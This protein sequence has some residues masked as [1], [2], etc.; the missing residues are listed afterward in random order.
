M[1]ISKVTS[2]GI[3][4]GTLSVEDIKDDAVTAAKLANSINTDI[5][6][7]VTGNTTANAALPK[8]GGAMTGAITTNSTFDGVDI[9]TRDGVLT[10]TTATAAAALPKAGGAMTGT[11][12][13]LR[14]TGIDDNA[15][16][17]AMTIDSSENVGVGVTSI[18]TWTKLKVAGT[19]GAQDVAK[20]ALYVTSPT[21]TANEG[22]GMRFSA[23]SGSHEA[24]GIIGM[25][26]NP[27]GNSGAM[28]F[29]TYNG[30]GTIPERMRIDNAGKVGIGTTA[31]ARTLHVNSAD[32]NI[33]SFEGHQGEGLV[34]SSGTNG[35]IDI[36]GYDD[37]ASAYNPI[38]IRAGSSG[39]R[40]TSNGLCFGAD[41]AAANALDDYEEGAWSPSIEAAN[42]NAANFTVGSAMYTKIGRQVNVTA[43]IH[44]IDLTAMTSG[45]Y[46][47][48][49]GLPYTSQDYADFAMGYR[50]AGYSNS[51]I[52]GGYVQSG[53]T[54]C[55]LMHG[56]GG[57][58]QQGSTFTFSKCMI[59]ITYPST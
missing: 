2:G 26:N 7:G 19:A 27:S 18:D 31:P 47:L 53:V 40:V 32:A 36:I 13:N 14:S 10:S 33:A 24:V 34:I 17:L 3:A 28:T 51:V 56:G 38:V 35:Q 49:K 43:Y 11:I 25:V 54:F 30:G 44:S 22:V 21:A 46:I 29:H 9:A 5:A 8:A 4:D 55:Y 45:S 20:Q 42:G 39:I 57:E 1:A 37:G 15:N 59:N 52:V 50:D 41:T 48:I 16:A 23:A 12:T 6:T 58:A